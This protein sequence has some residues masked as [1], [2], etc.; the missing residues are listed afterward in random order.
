MLK[1]YYKILG[2]TPAATQEEI[3]KAYRS[4][5][6]QWHPDRNPGVDTT[7]KMQDI[8]EAYNILKD[9]TTRARYD[10][11]YVKFYSARS[12]Q[13]QAEKAEA[14]YDIKD[15]NL[16]EDIKEA[17]KAAENYVREFYASLKKDSK[18]AAQGAWEEAK[19]P[20]GAAAIL[21]V[22]GLVVFAFIKNNPN[23]KPMTSSKPSNQTASEGI[24]GKTFDDANSKQ[25][26]IPQLR[27]LPKMDKGTDPNHWKTMVLYDAFSINVPVTVERQTK[28]S[29][30]GRELANKGMLQLRD[31]LII[32]N[33]KG[34]CDLKPDAKEQYCRIMINFIEGEKGDFLQKDQTEQLDWEYRQLLGEMVANEISSNS[35][36]IGSFTSEWV[37]VNNANAILVTYR[38]TGNNY[39]A[40]RPVNC[41]ILL[42]QDNN[43]F[44]K[45]IL[46][47]REHEANLWAADFEQVMRSF[48][49]KN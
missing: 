15:E 31:D 45:M 7:A 3:K 5:S 42:F 22:I 13:P 34:L 21:A 39:D 11:E 26:E 40:S 27:L 46:S 23:L 1:D 20:L 10:A 29:P 43:R 16:K 49:W 47:F 19:G 48:E 37:R 4:Q 36:Q 38:R 32:F 6:L 24:T 14:E 35:R 33:Q 17:R 8:N 41:K 12:E 2:I 18:K 30:Y 44:V 9:S 28:D 25:I